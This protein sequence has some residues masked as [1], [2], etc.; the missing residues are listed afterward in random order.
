MS[1]WSWRGRGAGDLVCDVI[2]KIACRLIQTCRYL[3]DCRRFPRLLTLW[4]CRISGSD[5]ERFAFPP[6]E[7]QSV[8]I[9]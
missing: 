3:L 5:L 1:L 8:W 7:D 9:R 4:F 2:Q 6:S